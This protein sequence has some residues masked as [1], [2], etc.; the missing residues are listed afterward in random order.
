MKL[1]IQFRLCLSGGVVNARHCEKAR[2]AFFIVNL[3]KFVPKPTLRSVFIQ[4][5]RQSDSV[6]KDVKSTLVI[7]Q[8]N[9]SRLKDFLTSVSKIRTLRQLCS[10]LKKDY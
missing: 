2:L 5:A 9:E 8:T 4:A 1:V 3:R 10:K 7:K 6:Q